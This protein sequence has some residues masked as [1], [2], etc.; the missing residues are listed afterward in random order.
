[1]EIALVDLSLIARMASPTPLFAR[2]FRGDVVMNK[3]QWI[4]N[5]E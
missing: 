2:L 5:N 3:E 1:V 4:E